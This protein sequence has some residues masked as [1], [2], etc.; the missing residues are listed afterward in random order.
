ME[1]RADARYEVTVEDVADPQGPARL[2]FA[3][4][5]LATV[6]ATHGASHDRTS[7]SE[8]GSVRV[9]AACGHSSSS[10]GGAS[11]PG[12][13]TVGGAN[14]LRVRMPRPTLVTR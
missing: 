9:P 6:C 8:A 7:A 10:T 2:S 3:R 12:S 11:R 1:R 14:F 13:C 4:I 5:R